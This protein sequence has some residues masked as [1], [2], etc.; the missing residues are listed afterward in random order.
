M[1]LTFTGKVSPTKERL[2][3]EKILLGLWGIKQKVD[4]YIDT[5]KLYEI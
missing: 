5:A 3:A 1:S 2:H 4:V